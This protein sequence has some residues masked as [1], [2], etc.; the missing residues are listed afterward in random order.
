MHI[1]TS[2][3]PWDLSTRQ[4]EI[5][6][7][8]SATNTQ[9]S[10][11]GSATIAI[12]GHTVATGVSVTHKATSDTTLLDFWGSDRSKLALTTVYANISKNDMPITVTVTAANDSADLVW[13]HTHSNSIPFVFPANLTYAPRGNTRP[14]G[15]PNYLATANAN[16]VTGGATVDMTSGG[17][18]SVQSGSNVSVNITGILGNIS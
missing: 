3:D 8:V 2:T 1:I 18:K 10:D 12:N 15:T 7:I 17:W 14:L 6:L 9:S 4:I 5:G 11:T 13:C 16:I